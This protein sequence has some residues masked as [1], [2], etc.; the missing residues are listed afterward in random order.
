MKLYS[1]DFI[2]SVISNQFITVGEDGLRPKLPKLKY[3]T[4]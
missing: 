4:W 2:E 3:A 1:Q